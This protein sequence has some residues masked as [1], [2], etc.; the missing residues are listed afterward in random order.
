MLFFASPPRCLERSLAEFQPNFI[1]YN[2]GTDVLKGDP[3]GLLDITPEGVMERDEI[4]FRAA[5]KRSIPLA[6]LMSG[7]YLRSSARVIANSILNLR[8]KA[9]LP[10]AQ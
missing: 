2:A 7:G 5:L 4:V 3:L 6:M 1:I 8:E 10:M 9:L